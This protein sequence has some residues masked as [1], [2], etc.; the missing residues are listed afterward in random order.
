MLNFLHKSNSINQLIKLLHDQ[1][2][3]SS[4]CCEEKKKD[5]YCIFF[6]TTLLWEKTEVRKD[7]NQGGNVLMI[8]TQATAAFF[9]TAARGIGRTQHEEA[10]HEGQKGMSVER[11]FRPIK[12]AQD[13]EMKARE[14]CSTLSQELQSNK[15]IGRTVTVKFKL[16]TFQVHTRSHTMQKYVNQAEEIFQVAWKLIKA[17]LPI[18][19]RLM[20]VRVSGFQHTD[21]GQLTLHQFFKYQSLK[22]QKNRYKLN[23]ANSE[24]IQNAASNAE[25]LCQEKEN[26]RLNN[27][28]KNQHSFDQQENGIIQE[29]IQNANA[30]FKG[31]L[32]IKQLLEINR[33]KNVQIIDNDIEILDQF[34]PKPLLL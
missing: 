8:F 4:Y 30:T 29:D 14:L 28:S 34:D 11:T 18:E 24:Q 26:V 3:S 5:Q 15:L 6:Y 31:Q 1:T 2:T 22:D 20:G 16:S 19:I 13:L 32:G 9:L 21:K 12:E 27:C 17:E 23:A 25:D 10:S 7:L 33:N